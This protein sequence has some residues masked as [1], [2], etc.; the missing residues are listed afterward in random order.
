MPGFCS[1]AM[2][3][4]KDGKT[5]SRGY[6]FTLKD[7]I[8]WLDK[9]AS[10]KDIYTQAAQL[11]TDHVNEGRA[12]HEKVF[13]PSTS[14]MSDWKKNEPKLRKNVLSASD[15]T[16]RLKTGKHPE[17]AEALTLWANQ[18]SAG[19]FVLSQHILLEKAKQ[20]GESLGV[21]GFSYSQGWLY[22]WQKRYGFRFTV[23]HGEASSAPQE[24]IELAQNNLRLV[25]EGY[26]PD[27]VFNQD[28]TGLCWRQVP[29]R[30]IAIGRA[31]GAKKDKN[32]VTVS[33]LCNVSGTRKEGL[34]LGSQR[35]LANGRR[36][37]SHSE[38]WAFDTAAT[39]VP[40]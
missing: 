26:T 31:S 36:T 33:C 22:N 27:D 37:F 15:G 5:R 38:T 3:R 40:G 25:L 29:S 14:T 23:L 1:V 11:L 9:L 24:G 8:W 35:G 13:P 32:R 6:A 19:N 16:K 39:V 7:K 20:F 28:E 4:E 34:S 12:D 30:T 2:T 17:L 18:K 10:I 21:T